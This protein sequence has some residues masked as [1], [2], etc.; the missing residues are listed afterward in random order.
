MPTNT[1]TDAPAPE[2]RDRRSASPDA[3]E[4]GRRRRRLF[5]RIYRKPTSKSTWY[6]RFPD[7]ERRRAPNGRVR[8]IVRSVPSRRA[9]EALLAEVRKA[10]MAGAYAPPPSALPPPT[11]APGPASE[12]TEGGSR[13]FT[14]VDALD[15]YIR[16]REIAGRS[17]NTLDSYCGHRDAIAQSPLGALAAADVTPSDLEAFRAWRRE[18]SWKT[19]RRPGEVENPEVK[20]VARAASNA[21]VNRALMVVGA[22]YNRLV[23]LGRLRE[24]PVLRISKGKEV[25]KPRPVLSKAE[26]LALMDACPVS[27]RPLVVAGLH[28]G[29]RVGELTRL[30]WGDVHLERGTLDLFRPKVGNASVVPLHPVLAEELLRL[31][32]RRAREE[33]RV[34]P[35][36]EAIFLSERGTP[37]VTYRKAW[38]RAIAA[39]GLAGRGFTFHSLRHT[40][41]CHFLE[42]GAAITDLQAVLGHA[43]IA[44][45]QI[46]ARMV[47]SR[48][49]ASLVALDYGA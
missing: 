36:T 38:D 35:D 45:T 7:P 28:T 21:T 32:E 16:S 8:E 48:T 1:T 4:G 13:A 44:T 33:K 46:Y 31:R 49:R 26:A 42:G 40:F 27:L 43:D 34:V 3:E 10:L 37:W 20:E 12:A 18:R 29:A 47:D 17:K 15:E 24:N 23:K 14:V 25:R 2:V 22:A 9:A 5:G 19:V 30:V 11:G 39:A 6:V 41:A